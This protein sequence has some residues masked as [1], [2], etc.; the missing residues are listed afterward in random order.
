VGR[1]RRGI[2]TNYFSRGAAAPGA[3]ESRSTPS[4]GTRLSGP[5]W[6]AQTHRSG[7][8]K[9]RAIALRMIRRVEGLACK[10]NQSPPGHA[11]WQKNN[12]PRARR[13]PFVPIGGLTSVSAQ[14]SGA[15]RRFRDGGGGFEVG[16]LIDR[17]ALARG[18]SRTTRRSSLQVFE[19]RCRAGG[20]L[21][22]DPSFQLEG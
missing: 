14:D 17:A 22:A 10:G 20:A 4:G 21:G 12:P 2:P 3:N 8:D 11:G 6:F 19:G 13:E 18:E 9:T 1:L 7:S 15:E 16:V 5:G